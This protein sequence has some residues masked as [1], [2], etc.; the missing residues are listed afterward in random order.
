MPQF[1][2]GVYSRCVPRTQHLSEIIDT[3]PGLQFFT[4]SGT[5][6]VETL[7]PASCVLLFMGLA[8]VLVL[9]RWRKG[10]AR[11]ACSI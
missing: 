10:H 9:A 5:V 4:G 1:S 7:E 2:S 11:A 3:D 8:S 6:F